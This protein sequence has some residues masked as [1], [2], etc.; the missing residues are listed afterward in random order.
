MKMY[1]IEIIRPSETV[2]KLP[3]SAMAITVADATKSRSI[4][5]RAKRRN[6]LHPRSPLPGRTCQLIEETPTTSLT[7][8]KPRGCDNLATVGLNQGKIPGSK[9]F[10]IGY[11]DG[12]ARR[13]SHAP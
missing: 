9:I 7:Q 13:L 4:D 12:A 6:F 11:G 3:R 2:S 1:G 5:N 8:D 10:L